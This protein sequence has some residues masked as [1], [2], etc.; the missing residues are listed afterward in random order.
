MTFRDDAAMASNNVERATG[1]LRLKRPF[2]EAA[3]KH[4]KISIAPTHN[5]EVVVPRRL[6]FQT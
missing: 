1:L 5:R 2:G 6:T 3:V 4:T